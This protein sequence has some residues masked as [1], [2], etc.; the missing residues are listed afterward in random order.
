M[1][2]SIK[3]KMMF[4]KNENVVIYKL[5][6]SMYTKIFDIKKNKNISIYWSDKC[7]ELCIK[8]IVESKISKNSNYNFFIIPPLS[9]I[10]IE[11]FP[12]NKINKKSNLIVNDYWTLEYFNQK[13]ENLYLW[14]IFIYTFTRN[15]QNIIYLFTKL[16]KYNLKWFFINYSSFKLIDDESLI[17]LN[18]KKIEIWIFLEDE[19]IAYSPKCYYLINKKKKWDLSFN[20][21]D[22]S[23]EKENIR[24]ME[25]NK[26]TNETA[27]LDRKALILKTKK[28]K[29]LKE[30]IWNSNITY[31]I[32]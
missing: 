3:I 30:L 18:E 15:F 24:E 32:Y 9:D 19:I 14:R 4:A 29:D 26:K 6:L 5:K 8:N 7:D 20:I 1:F 31:L 2:L 17:F 28:N 11:K 13:I 27:L 16:E 25:I 23:C 10:S 21:C 22:I 12:I